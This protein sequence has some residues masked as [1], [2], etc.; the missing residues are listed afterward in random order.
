MQ[1]GKQIQS[2]RRQFNLTQDELAAKLYVSRQ[3]ISNWEN[4]RNY[5]D[6]ENL[7]LLSTLFDT[8]IDQLVKGDVIQM[9]HLAFNHTTNRDVKWMLGLMLAAIVALA[10]A[11]FLPL[12][13][14]FIPTGVLFALAIIPATHIEYYK[15]KA[16]VRTYREIL[17]YMNGEDV[18][19]L[20]KQR[21]SWR[22]HTQ[23]ALIVI[24]FGLVAGLLTLIALVPFILWH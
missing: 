11:A 1:I 21:D 8:S 7:V 4:D 23:M 13:W 5:P 9:K 22:S 12:P 2:H 6:I 14:A 16:D 20:R 3:T 24:G 18:T 10:P 17:A 19:Q 15:K